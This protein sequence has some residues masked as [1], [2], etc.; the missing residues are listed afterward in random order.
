MSFT[1]TEKD[2]V[3]RVSDLKVRFE[4]LEKAIRA[5][6]SEALQYSK[7]GEDEIT[8]LAKIN[9][10]TWL[11]D[12]AYFGG[13]YSG[14]LHVDMSPYYQSKVAARESYND[15]LDSY[16]MHFAEWH[17]A[18]KEISRALKQLVREADNRCSLKLF[19]RG[20]FKAFLN[21][22][23]NI[24]DIRALKDDLDLRQII[25]N[26]QAARATRQ[27]VN[28]DKLDTRVRYRAKDMRIIPASSNT[29][30]FTLTPK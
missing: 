25:F 22:I 17:S 12:D 7:I 5:L 8:E 24:D 20:N 4:Q 2:I 28:L 23:L 13:R 14:F 29:P 10:K 9:L 21:D 30:H 16:V 11:E 19:K 3:K 26:T 27:K 6:P 18:L 15:E 1:E